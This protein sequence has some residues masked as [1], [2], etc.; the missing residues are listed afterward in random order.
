MASSMGR[1]PPRARAVWWRLGAL[2]AVILLL[3]LG[4]GWLIDSLEFT[5]SPR[6]SDIVYQMLLATTVVYVLAMAVPFVPGIEIGVAIMLAIGPAG[7]PFVYLSTLLALA[8]AFLVGRF[9]SLHVIGRLFGW[10]RVERARD[11]VE[12]MAA[13]VPERRLGL[14]LQ[15]LPAGWARAMLRARYLAAALV[16]NLP[17]NSVIGGAG[18]IAMIAGMSRLFSFPVFMLTMALA[19]TP[20]PLL[21]LLTR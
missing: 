12:Q 1:E 9:V 8:L 4:G 13:C 3:N 16:L 21:I 18:G 2:L 6:N 11:L 10:L 15:Q 17:G 19:I 7:V 14:L 20:V 5:L